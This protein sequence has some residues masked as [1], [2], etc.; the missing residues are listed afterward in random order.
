MIPLGLDSCAAAG[1]VL[2]LAAATG[3]AVPTTQQLAVAMLEPF[4]V[5]CECDA[6]VMPYCG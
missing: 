4:N 5:N 2:A 1:S 6:V 3:D